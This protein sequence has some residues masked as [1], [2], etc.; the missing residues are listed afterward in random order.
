MN[1]WTETLIGI[2]HQAYAAGHLHQ[3]ES[4]LR[5][6]LG[7]GARDAHAL[8][9]IGHLAYLQGRLADAE[10]FLT[11]ALDIAPDHANARN[12][13]GETLRAMGRNE[14]AIHQLE[15]AVALDPA[16]GHAYGNLAAALVA[17]DRPDDAL[18]WAQES[19]WRSA[20]K[21]VAHADFG[22]ILGR[23]G[24]SRE[25]LHQY[26]LALALKPDD[27]RTRYFAS[28]V[29]LGLGDMPAAWADHEARLMLPLG[30]AGRRTC[31]QP[32]W[33]GQDGIRGRTILL[34]AEQGLG[35]T[36][37][38][39]RYAPMVAERGA[40]VLLEVQPGL[41]PLL[42]GM[43]GVA[44]VFETGETLPAFD[45]RCP[46]MSL[47]AAFRTGPGTIP[48]AT[49]YLAVRQDRMRA[50]ERRLKP[51][52]R[53]RMGFAWSGNPGHA[54]DRARSVPLADLARVLGR[55]D[56]AWHV[57][58]RD[59]RPDD[60]AVLARI[61]GMHDH[62]GALAD[63]GETAALVSLMDLVVTVDTAVAHLAGALGKPVWLL[64][65]HAP[66][67][68]WMQGRADSPW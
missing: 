56:I 58:Q 42:E 39:V 5:L 34:H 19:L 62:S 53:P 29:R 54:S 51:G 21:A 43:P 11:A 13:L 15:R 18:R 24:R 10:A 28:L 4:V 3:A 12:D 38:F 27:A 37:Q 22:S 32:R 45:L 7:R 44:A 66:D 68:R 2:A 23:L 64:L 6:V 60:R 36:I 20:D 26:K 9:F 61:G 47:P 31:S 40:T 57:V 46:L 67:W 49:P 50:W 30:V 55:R 48:A 59:M 1:A 14:D 16:L 8:Y 63:F 41:R 65:A 25:A 33:R 35:D 17:V 52:R